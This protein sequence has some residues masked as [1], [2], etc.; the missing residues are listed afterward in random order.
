MGCLFC[1]LTLLEFR[2]RRNEIWNVLWNLLSPLA[3][4]LPYMMP[5]SLNINSCLLSSHCHSQTF[6]PKV[7]IFFFDFFFFCQISL[8]FLVILTGLCKRKKHVYLFYIFGLFFVSCYC[9]LHTCVCWIFFLFYFFL[10]KT[11]QVKTFQTWNS[12]MPIDQMGILAHFSRF[13]NFNFLLY[14]ERHLFASFQLVVS[15][16]ACNIK[17]K[18]NIPFSSLIISFTKHFY[19]SWS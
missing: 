8:H 1:S 10:F 2:W 5:S 16:H 7:F 3:A 19:P 9:H 12:I 17:K 18:Y 4:T 6:F 15:W 11:L 14:I 13:S